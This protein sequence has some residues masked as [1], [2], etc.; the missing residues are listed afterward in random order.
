MQQL[1]QQ[2]HRAGFVARD[3]E[4]EL[5][6]ANFD[7]P[8]EDER[9][10]FLFHVHGDA[11]V[12]KTFLVREFEQL[13]RARG[14]LTAYVDE[15]AGGVPE[16][17]DAMCR[18]FA[19]QGHR[20]KDLERLLATYRERRHE[21]ETAVLAAL[22]P[23]AQDPSAGSMAVARA[24]LAGL[25]MVPGLGAFTGVL[26]PAQLAQG[27]D[28]LRAGLGARFRNHE[29]VR[30]VLDPE[31]VLTP[32]LAGEL[33]DAAASVP[34]IVLFFD[35]YER[36][37]S[38]LDGW[39][40]D[41]V[42]TDRHGGLPATV[43][44]VTAG[45]SPFDLGRWGGFADVVT[46]LPLHPFTEAEARG[47]LAARGVTAEPVVAEVLRLTG[48]LP[49]LV[50]TLAKTRPTGPHDLYDPSSTAVER[51]LKWEP[52]PVRRSAALAGALPRWLDADVFWAVADCPREQLDELYSWVGD[53]PFT[54]E[55]TARLHYHDVVRAPML[56]LQRGRSP[57]GWAERQRRL[58]DVFRQWREEAE[59]GREAGE[60]WSD[61][62]WRELLLAESYHRLCVPER[63][64]LTAVLGDLVAACD[65]GESVAARWVRVLEEA[66]RDT[67]REAV[68]GLGR[69][70]SE[71]LAGGG[72]E[73]VLEVLL[74]EY[75]PVLGLVRFTGD[76][77]FGAPSGGGPHIVPG[78]AAWGRPG[79]GEAGQT[80]D[81]GASGTGA[82][83]TGPPGTGPDAPAW[84]VLLSTGATVR[85]VRSRAVARGV[86]GEYA[87]AVADLDTALAL[88][89]DDPRSLALRGEYHRTLRRHHEA[90]ADLGRAVGLDPAHDYAWA[91]LGAT[92]L[93][94][95]EPAAALTALDR[96]LALKPDYSWALIRRA[97]VW[98]ALDEPARQL[99]DLDRAVALQPDSPWA[100]CERGDALRAAG[101][102]E[103]ALAHYDHALALDPGYASAY[104]SR[105]VALSRLGR[106]DRALRD[107]DRALELSPSYE[108]ARTRRDEVRHRLDEAGRR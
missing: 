56:R 80:P 76:E 32:V 31:S 39:L 72:T 10:R 34:W 25:G 65:Q 38:F 99:A 74:A 26:D 102:D 3:A 33:S 45:R 67:D 83:G 17:L 90:L 57:R 108:W 58:A 94:L 19:A 54:D 8:P 18:Q 70:L 60:L 100:H 104:A 7:T 37:G 75:S 73:A 51:F 1:V 6:R 22:E 36:T 101:R 29:D 47:L 79:E 40:R 66:G 103:E 107:L 15:S 64:A 85:A 5:F 55:R 106:H 28:R 97:R 9:H 48:G 2:R 21:A 92:R 63:E 84:N 44:V 77:P 27:A 61:E 105:G 13:A 96:A 68:A 59:A 98:R 24:G 69:R 16:A 52:D 14:A 91:S 23:E 78:G 11:G 82:S 87:A 71:A 43:V 89:P 46:A 30:L 86:R 53:L 62:E 50:S 42:T 41:L 93:A 12:G 49:V 95:G 35:T 4:R 88:R 81:T 20:A